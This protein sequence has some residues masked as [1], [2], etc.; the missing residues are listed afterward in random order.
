M[1]MYQ[2][3][4]TMKEVFAYFPDRPWYREGDAIYFEDSD[5]VILVQEYDW[6]NII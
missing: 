2:K 1:K 4:M 3:T 6:D 5:D